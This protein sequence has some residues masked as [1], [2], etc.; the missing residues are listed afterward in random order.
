M[1]K[2]S[3]VAAF[4][5]MILV[6]VAGA[7][8]SCTKSEDLLNKPVEQLTAKDM[9]RLTAVL[10]T[11]FGTIKFKFYSKEAPETS[12]NFIKLARSGFYNNLIFHRVLSGALIQGGDPNVDGSGGPGWT[13]N[14]EFS[15]LKHTKGTVAM[16]RLPSDINSAGSQFYICVIPLP[17]LDGQYTIFGQVTEGQEVVD[18]IGALPTTGPYGSPP[19]RPLQDAIMTKVYIELR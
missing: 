16:A 1:A 4:V 6:S 14:A 17:V 7:M 12:R 11:N 13:M 9:E 10:E 19:D 5:V 8:S 15:K 3:M 2:K 18:K